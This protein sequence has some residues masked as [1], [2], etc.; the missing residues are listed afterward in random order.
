MDFVYPGRFPRQR[1]RRGRGALALW[2]YCILASKTM[3][4][5]CVYHILPFQGHVHPLKELTFSQFF[6]SDPKVAC[7]HAPARERGDRTEGVSTVTV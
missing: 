6:H 5:L 3:V 2:E 4:L 1:L 7:A